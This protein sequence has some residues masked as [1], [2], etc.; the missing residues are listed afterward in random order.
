MSAPAAKAKPIALAAAAIGLFTAM[1]FGWLASQI[2]I[3]AIVVLAFAAPPAVAWRPLPARAVL[4]AYLPFAAAW[5]LFVVVYLRVM[6]WLDLT[7]EPQPM[8]KDVARGGVDGGAGGITAAGL[9]LVVVVIAPLFEEI[10][11]RGYLWAGLRTRLPATA[12][13]VIT[14]ATFGA[15]HGWSYALPIAVLGAFFGFLRSRHDALLPAVYAHALHN[16]LTVAVTALW[17]GHLDLLY[18]R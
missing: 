16:G 1:H 14:A 15:F 8:L 10:V 5:L 3:A 4:R 6:H 11:F 2:A 18:P 12:T 17:P 7:V 13:N 9:F